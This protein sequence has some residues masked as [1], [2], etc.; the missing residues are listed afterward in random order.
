VGVG[1][2]VVLWRHT[3]IFTPAEAD[4]QASFASIR[5][6]FKGRPPLIEIKNSGVPMMDFR[7]NRLPAAAPRQHVRHFQAI[8]W[9]SKG[10]RMVRSSVPVWWMRF[11]GNNLLARLGVPL[12][13]FALTVE[14]IER[15]GPGIIIDF[16]PP[17]GGHMLVWV[18]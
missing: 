14:D 8:V 3:A 18:E 12:G 11:S 13:D 2:G 17:G 5:E 7:I 1:V 10:G 15:Y 4:A 9:D 16:Q 6:R